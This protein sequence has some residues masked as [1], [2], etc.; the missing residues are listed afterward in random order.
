MEDQVDKGLETNWDDPYYACHAIIKQVG[1]LLIAIYLCLPLICYERKISRCNMGT[2]MK[3]V[4]HNLRP[5]ML[6]VDIS[7]RKP[8]ELYFMCAMGENWIKGVSLQQAF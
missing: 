3:P 4:N 6:T 5:K 2:D 8:N 7:I 1:V